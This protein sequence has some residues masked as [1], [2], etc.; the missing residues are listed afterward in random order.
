LEV[1]DIAEVNPCK[2]ACAHFTFHH[3]QNHVITS[4]SLAAPPTNVVGRYTQNFHYLLSLHRVLE[5]AAVSWKPT[6]F[7]SCFGAKRKGESYIR[8][9]LI[10]FADE[11]T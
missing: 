7:D 5:K 9:H 11:H 10:E 3:L 2:L 4:H 6:D 1:N 8:L